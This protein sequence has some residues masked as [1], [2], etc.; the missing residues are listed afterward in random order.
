MPSNKR[1][2]GSELNHDNWNDEQKVENTGDFK[3]TAEDEPERA[4]K[5]ARRRVASGEE[6]SGTTNDTITS[7]ASITSEDDEAKIHSE[8]SQQNYSCY[9]PTVNSFTA[10]D[11]QVAQSQTTQSANYKQVPKALDYSLDHAKLHPVAE[12]L[13]HQPY[14]I[15]T[16]SAAKNSISMN[17]TAMLSTHSQNQVM[18]AVE[19]RTKPK[20]IDIESDESQEESK[21]IQISE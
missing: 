17:T 5:V 1:S 20:A 16:N 18:S 8:F 6:K 13:H 4:R 12:S 10:S 19:E 14:A 21:N 2:A 11:S 15:P 3:K 7:D 9:T